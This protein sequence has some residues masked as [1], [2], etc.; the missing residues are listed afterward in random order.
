[1]RLRED[2]YPPAGQCGKKTRS[3]VSGGI[4]CVARVETHRQ[5]DDQNHKAHSEGLQS[6]WDGIIV[7]IDDGQDTNDQC[8]RANNLQKKGKDRNAQ[9]KESQRIL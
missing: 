1:M 8:R 7:G 4:D 6:L 5:A 9:F 3:E 2:F